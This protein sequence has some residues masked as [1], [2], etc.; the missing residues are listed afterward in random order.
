MVFMTATAVE[1]AASKALS[2]LMLDLRG[3]LRGI[4]IYDIIFTT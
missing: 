2:N 4:C 3:C 1:Y